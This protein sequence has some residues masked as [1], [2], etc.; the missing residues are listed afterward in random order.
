MGRIIVR[1]AQFLFCMVFLIGGFGVRPC[2]ADSTNGL[3][4]YYSFDALNANGTVTDLSG[5]NNT[6]IINGHVSYTPS[7]RVGGAYQFDGGDG[8]IKIPASPSLNLGNNLTLATWY[9]AS[10][11]RKNQPASFQQNPLLE[12]SDGTVSG[13][14]LWT[15]TIGYQWENLGTGANLIDT[16]GDAFHY[17]IS[18]NDQP[19]NEWHHLV[20]TYDG[21]NGRASVYIDGQLRNQKNFGTIAPQTSWDLYI[22]KRPWD[23]Q[24]F[25]GLLDELRVYNRVLSSNEI[26][27]LYNA[28][29]LGHVY[30]NFE[31]NNGT[32]PPPGS[33]SGA[34]EYGWG[35]NGAS[36]ELSTTQV[37]AGVQ[38][39]HVHSNN[40]FGGTTIP[41]QFQTYHVNFEPDRNDRLTFWIWAD[42]S[43]AA[44]NEVRVRFFDKNIYRDTGD[45]FSGFEVFATKKAKFRTWTQ[46]TILLTQLPNNFDWTSVDKINF[47]NEFPGDYYLDD[48]Q[49][50]S[51]DRVYQTFEPWTCSTGNPG[52]CGWAWNGNI[53]LETTLAHEGVQSWKLQTLDFWGGTG[54]KSQE[55]RCD[56]K[57]ACSFQDF[58]HVDLNPTALNPK[59]YDR[60][61]FWV[62]SLAQN[63]LANNVN[64]QFFDWDNPKYNVEPF[65]IWTKRAAD[66]GQWTQLSVPLSAL[67]ADLNLDDLNKIQLQVYWPGTYYF[68]DIR[69]TKGP[70]L[71]INQANLPTGVVQWNDYAGAAFYTLQESTA[72]SDG[73]WTTVYTGHQNFFNYNRLQ[74]ASLR[75][76]WETTS[77]DGHVPYLSDW[78]DVVL[79]QPKPALIKYARLQQG[80]IQ[81]VPI[82]QTT[83][84]EVQ[85]GDSK[86]GPWVQIYKGP[87]KN[88]S[89][90]LGKSY[91]VR[92][93]KTD[94]N[95]QIIDATNFS[96]ALAYN[97]N[98]F[99]KAV[100]TDLRENQGNGPVIK[101]RGVN[102]GNYFL[103]EPWMLLGSGAPA[104][105][106]DDWTIRSILSQR[107]GDVSMQSLITSYQNTYIQEEDLN[108]LF[109]MGINF[110][111]LPLYYRNIRDLNAKGSW[112]PGL[113]DFSAVDKILDMCADRGMY[114]LLD[115]HGAP[116]S[117]STSFHTGRQSAKSPSAG[118]YHQLFNPANKVYRQRTAELWR[119][120]ANHYK[121]NTVVLGYDLINEPF[122]AIDP[123][124]YPN[125]SQGY[126]A[127]WSLYDWLYR[128]IRL[129]GSSGGANDT[130]HLIVMEGIPSNK[131]WDTLP[132]PSVFQWTNIM[133]Q[134]HYYGFK[135][136]QNG[137]IIGVLNLAE[138]QKYLIDGQDGVD[139][140]SG[141]VRYSKQSLYQVPVM[142]GEFNGFGDKAV[143]D[144]MLKTFNDQ[145]WSWS[146]WSYKMYDY[147]SEWGMYDH[148]GDDESIADFQND[149]LND[150]NRK[151]SKYDTATHHLPNASLLK[152]LKGYIQAP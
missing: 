77:S 122:G 112:V 79:Y 107:F 66:Y 67:P 7:G 113:Y 24:I 97:P 120:I 62:Y 4:L 98:G 46:I 133:Y 93:I 81:L 58:W 40:S 21:T 83:L 125:I 8:F 95:Q 96:P 34:P 109:R 70:A 80:V 78:S 32:P 141:K 90:L 94:A 86:N 118:F 106:P 72:G 85:R 140:W 55:R 138:E 124:Y 126:Q 75:V 74:P 1:L 10:D 136:D 100:A 49:I 63:G 15:N 92:G 39:W 145:N 129:P 50:E 25:S 123:L 102:L 142:V 23:L 27:A 47:V 57:L 146:M 54:M 19:F 84:Y 88:I 36:T 22:G 71:V 9:N 152:I 20:V 26:N 117:Q 42:P 82:P 130:V 11:N 31:P 65:T 127:L 33:P 111:R 131:D 30:Q 76:R 59:P 151:I 103:L 115:L 110:V 150:L 134:F 43:N 6:G 105:I 44:D 119:A 18:T 139:Q 28:G 48:I 99:I 16:K 53:D 61:T 60:L 144:L 148:F 13:V 14:H 37:H 68:D 101:L 114:V 35:L 51:A 56:S 52:D 135:F 87:V 143:W 17:V 121:K 137:Q 132:N 89:A 2:H 104:S 69:A 91:R 73:P 41:A 45:A 64:V 128:T 3:V 38:A 116:G 147:P 149:S 108:N 5:Y 29:N 12:Y